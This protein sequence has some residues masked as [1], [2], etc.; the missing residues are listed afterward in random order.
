MNWGKTVNF[1]ICRRKY[2]QPYYCVKNEIRHVSRPRELS[3]SYGAQT[4]TM[5]RA[6]E[7]FLRARAEKDQ[8]GAVLR[9]EIHKTT[10]VTADEKRVGCRP[11]S[12]GRVK[13]NRKGVSV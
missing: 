3:E 11:G 4:V 12:N 10:Y 9:L 1:P 6:D 7:K 8:K 2:L 5:P 13:S